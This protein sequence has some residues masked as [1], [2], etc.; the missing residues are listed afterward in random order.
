MFP[1]IDLIAGA[2]QSVSGGYEVEVNA[3]DRQKVHPNRDSKLSLVGIAA[4]TVSVIC[5]SFCATQDVTHCLFPPITRREIKAIDADLAFAL[6]CRAQTYMYECHLCTGHTCACMQ[7]C[8][9]TCHCPSLAAS[10]A[11]PL[12]HVAPHSK[13]DPVNLGAGVCDSFGARLLGRWVVACY[14]QP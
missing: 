11:R 12:C 13:S 1:L 9:S 8:L 2:V 5:R 10:F 4:R 14:K 6:H 7:A 3:S